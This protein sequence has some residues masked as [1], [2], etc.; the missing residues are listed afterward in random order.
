MA[1]MTICDQHAPM[2]RSTH[3]LTLVST[4]RAQVVMTLD[5]SLRILASEGLHLIQRQLIIVRWSWGKTSSLVHQ[6][7]RSKQCRVNVDQL[8]WK[9][10]TGFWGLWA[11]G[12]EDRE[13]VGGAV[14][15]SLI[16]NNTALCAFCKVRW[17]CI[18]LWRCIWY[19][20]KKGWRQGHIYGRR[21]GYSGI[22]WGKS[23]I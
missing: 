10:E 8:W 6:Y 11:P 7:S 23:R 22:F 15:R 14:A 2:K 16:W 21:G 4:R 3:A 9:V 13:R 19:N 5:G 20:K 1:A 12:A 17:R 18:F